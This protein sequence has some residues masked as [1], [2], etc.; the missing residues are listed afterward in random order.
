MSRQ[1]TVQAGDTLSQIAQREG[2]RLSDITGFRSGDPNLIFPGEVLTLPGQD[3]TPRTPAQV[4]EQPPSGLQP[5]VVDPDATEAFRATQRIQD[6]VPETMLAGFEAQ[7][8]R[9]LE[10]DRGRQEELRTERRSLAEQQAETMSRVDMEGLVRRER[11]ALGVPEFLDAQ[12]ASIEEMRGLRQQLIELETQKGEALATSEGRQA[13]LGFIRG[14]QARIAEQ[15]DRREASVA[16]RLQAENAHMQAMQGQV[17]QARSL[18]SDIVQAATFDTEMELNRIQLFREVNA[19]ELAELDQSIQNDLQQSQRFWENRLQTERQEKQQVMELMINAPRAGINV[20]DTLEEA[21]EK[22][23]AFGATQI[24][25]EGVA[26]AT[27]MPFEQWRETDQAQ[28][29]LQ[30][31]QQRQRMSLSP[32]ARDE[33]L[34]EQ[35]NR[36]LRGE[37]ELPSTSGVGDS[38]F[39]MADNIVFQQLQQNPFAT[40]DSLV[41]QL[42]E[43]T[44]LNISDAQR[45]VR[46]VRQNTTFIDENFIQQVYGGEQGVIQEASESAG[47]YFSKEELEELAEQAGFMKG[48]PFFRRPDIESYTKTPEF[49]TLFTQEVIREVE[50]RRQRF[51][52][53]D[54]DIAKEMVEEITDQ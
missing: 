10:E 36:G 9:Q 26:G 8:Q 42:R 12:R 51:G 21:A 6:A 11:E 13:P 1:V 38:A 44:D 27:P 4:A 7:R 50:A 43:N 23:R 24:G 20:N 2:V 35:Y 30:E 41:R 18:I 49:A 46:D 39:A 52:E 3:V 29:L 40:E 37:I 16:A 47:L 34:R 19:Q 15:F 28:N 25:T 45:V 48:L 5:P 31:E 54:F 53:S 17:Q 33:F 32:Q 22:A 14:E